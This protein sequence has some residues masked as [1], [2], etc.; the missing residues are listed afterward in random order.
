[1]VCT[2]AAMLP[3]AAE[4]IPR[5]CAAAPAAVARTPA[6]SQDP[7]PRAEPTETRPCAL[8]VTTDPLALEGLG[9]ATPVVVA[10]AATMEADPTGVVAE[11]EDRLMP[12]G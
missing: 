4:D 7:L 8:P 5:E 2:R 9:A 12:R 11:E 3:V 10:G 6:A 1:V